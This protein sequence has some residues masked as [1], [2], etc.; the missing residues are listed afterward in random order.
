MIAL[1]QNQ[2][3][4]RRMGSGLAAYPAAGF[5]PHKRSR[6]GCVRMCSTPDSGCGVGIGTISPSD[7][8]LMR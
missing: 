6:R 1:K 5:C 2:I 4:L 8:K 7:R 3:D